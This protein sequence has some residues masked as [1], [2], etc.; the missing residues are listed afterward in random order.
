MGRGGIRDGAGRPRQM[1]RPASV[2]VDLPAHLR[3][4]LDRAA[5]RAG[6]SRA[7][8]VREAVRQYLGTPS[9]RE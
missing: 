9:S 2:R 5:R 1:D 8:L 4:R 7:E 3:D 6:C